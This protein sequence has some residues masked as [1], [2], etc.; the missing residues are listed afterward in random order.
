MIDVID[1]PTSTS[2][3]RVLSSLLYNELQNEYMALVLGV[4]TSKLKPVIAC[5][6][7]LLVFLS[8][9]Y[10]DARCE[11]CEFIMTALPEYLTCILRYLFGCGNV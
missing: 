5:I 9:M 10:S 11:N 4:Y 7:C 6:I 1:V 2:V 8:E 3:Y